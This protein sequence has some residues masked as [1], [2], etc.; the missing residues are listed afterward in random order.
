[1]P[2]DLT[3]NSPRPKTLDAAVD[4]LYSDM[5]EDELAYIH[6]NGSLLLHH[7]FGTAIRNHWGLW[8]QSSAL[9]KYFNE[10]FG[11]SHADDMSGLIIGSLV[12]KVRNETFDIEGEV[13]FYKNHW[14]QLGID[15]LTQR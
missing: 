1:M 15:P 10:T 12:A 5:N 4:I 7:G 11:L 9:H 8:D 2:I 6:E 14:K 3:E 13:Q